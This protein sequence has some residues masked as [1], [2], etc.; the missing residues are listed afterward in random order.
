MEFLAHGDRR[1]P[2][3]WTRG[4][5]AVLFGYGIVANTELLLIGHRP[6]PR[7]AM[8]K[9]EREWASRWMRRLCGTYVTAKC[10]TA[11]FW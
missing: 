1:M 6:L 4:A 2:P 10:G 5:D 3:Q 8:G 7:V 9:E 11:L